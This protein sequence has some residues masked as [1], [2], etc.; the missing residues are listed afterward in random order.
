MSILNVN[1]INPVGGGSTITIAGIASVTNNISVG[2]SVTASSFHG[3]GSQLTGI[4]SSAIS[5]GGSVKIQANSSGATV[6]GVLTATNV[7]VGSSVTATSFFGSGAGLTGVS[8]GLYQSHAVICDQKASNVQGGTSLTGQFRNRDLNTELLDPD[9]IV[10]IS[11]NHFILQAGTY[12]I[13]WDCPFYESGRGA[14]ELVT[15]A[16]SGSGSATRIAIGAVAWSGVSGGSENYAHGN[17]RGWHRVT[18]SSETYFA[19]RYQCD[20]S[21]ST[22]GLGVEAQHTD[23]IFTVVE[24]YKET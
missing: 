11:N 19:I 23:S 20:T 14:T 21:V 2:N 16:N 5:S 22:Y 18:I 8:A 24:I 17:S 12:Y 10:S 6:T 15:V 9:N 13:Q 7:S 4:D 3:D 1:K